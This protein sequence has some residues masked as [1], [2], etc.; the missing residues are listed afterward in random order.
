MSWPSVLG[1]ERDGLEIT[2]EG[3]TVPL[4]DHVVALEA[5]GLA[6]ER[7]REPKP[8]PSFFAK[9]PSWRKSARIPMMLTYRAFKR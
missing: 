5:A 6:I 2:F 3:W 7:I 4:E 1:L 9:H 8:D